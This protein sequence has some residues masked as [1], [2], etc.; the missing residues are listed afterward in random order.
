MT[1]HQPPPVPPGPPEHLASGGG[2]RVD[3]LASAGFL[4]GAAGVLALSFVLV[5]SPTGHGTHHQLAMPPCL[6]H[7]L[8]RIPCPLCGMTTAFA[9]MARGHVMA[10]WGC[11][12]LGPMAYLATWLAAIF[13]A[14][15]LVFGAPLIPRFALSAR[16]GVGLLVVVIGGWVVNIWRALV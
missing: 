11:H 4:A 8:T 10:A 5:P 6:L 13:A 1:D 15:G 14:R 2:S 3:R 12:V 9:H 16:F 7:L